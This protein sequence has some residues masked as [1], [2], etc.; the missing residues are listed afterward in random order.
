[1]WFLRWEQLKYV[2]VDNVET[3][4][5]FTDTVWSVLPVDGLYLSVN[6][7][8]SEGSWNLYSVMFYVQSYVT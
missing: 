6:K 8:S 2:L 5:P 4:L 3:T 7:I 1:M